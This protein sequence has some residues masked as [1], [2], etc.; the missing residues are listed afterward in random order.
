MVFCKQNLFPKEICKK[1][2]HSDS[3]VFDLPTFQFPQSTGRFFCVHLT[4][5]SFNTPLGTLHIVWHS[6]C[7]YIGRQCDVP[8]SVFKE[9]KVMLSVRNG[10]KCTGSDP[11]RRRKPLSPEEGKTFSSSPIGEGV[12]GRL[13][14]SANSPVGKRKDPLAEAVEAANNERKG[15]DIWTSRFPIG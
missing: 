11:R 5:L 12:D 14:R 4:Q 13:Q 2:K 15:W 1:K 3:A 6:S 9:G 8:E 7:L 10:S